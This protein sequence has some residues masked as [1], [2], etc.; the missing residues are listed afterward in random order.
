MESYNS[1]GCKDV[2][3]IIEEWNDPP[4]DPILD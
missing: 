4:P 1:S 3:K 2:K